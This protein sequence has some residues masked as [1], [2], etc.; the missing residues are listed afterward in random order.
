M[1]DSSQKTQV[2]YDES[3][4]LDSWPPTLRG[5][6]YLVVERE[7]DAALSDGDTARL[8]VDDGVVDVGEDAVGSDDVDV[9]VT[10]LVPRRTHRVRQV[11]VC[12]VVQQLSHTTSV[13]RPQQTI[14]S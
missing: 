7:V 10:V 6:L 4:H 13:S 11:R 3:Y 1:Q 12:L 9:S 14:N 8:G 5:S 2:Q